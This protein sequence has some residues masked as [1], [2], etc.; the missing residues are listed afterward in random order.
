MYFVYKYIIINWLSQFEKP[1]DDNFRAALF[2]FAGL[3]MYLIISTNTYV[4]Y[5]TI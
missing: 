3:I 2:I 5:I 1:V 4:K